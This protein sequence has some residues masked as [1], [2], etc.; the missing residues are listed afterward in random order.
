MLMGFRYELGTS[1]APILNVSFSPKVT[2]FVDD[3]ADAGGSTP[4]DACAP[5]VMPPPF[6]DVVF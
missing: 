3:V 4:A 6:F 5:V 1:A 2:F